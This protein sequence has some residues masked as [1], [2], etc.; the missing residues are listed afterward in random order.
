MLIL[1]LPAGTCVEE[2]ITLDDIDSA[3]NLLDRLKYDSEQELKDVT[4]VSGFE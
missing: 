3:R 1:K 4:S 2:D